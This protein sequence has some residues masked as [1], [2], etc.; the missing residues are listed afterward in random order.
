[1]E[2]KEF[3]RRQAINSGLKK[4]SA[5]TLFKWQS[6]GLSAAWEAPGFQNP[7]RFYL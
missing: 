5:L 6:R 3:Y 7:S 2:H 4:S 1:M